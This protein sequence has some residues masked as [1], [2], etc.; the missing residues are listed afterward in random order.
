MVFFM[1][2]VVLMVV[3][4]CCYW[5]LV[6]N[7]RLFFYVWFPFGVCGSWS[8][9]WSFL[10]FFMEKEV[11]W[12]FKDCVFVLHMISVWGLCFWSKG[13]FL[14]DFWWKRKTFIWFHGLIFCW[15]MIFV[16][17]KVFSFWM[18]GG[19]V[20]WLVFRGLF[21]DMNWLFCLSVWKLQHSWLEN[22]L[23]CMVDNLMNTSDLVAK[24]STMM[25]LD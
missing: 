10:S 7:K 16:I 21:A 1:K 8:K 5:L 17:L 9:S 18:S 2:N 24:T 12:S 23:L 13:S 4:Q 6:E 14:W 25:S 22:E 20:G 3:L 19:W 15:R 11:F